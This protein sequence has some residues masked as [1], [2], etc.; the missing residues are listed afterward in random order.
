M[1]EGGELTYTPTR[2]GRQH[3][4]V[5]ALSLQPDCSWQSTKAELA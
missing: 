4:P 1:R 3:A 2:D 5:R